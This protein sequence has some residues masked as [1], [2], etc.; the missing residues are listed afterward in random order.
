MVDLTDQEQAA[1]RANV[2]LSV[3]DAYLER[4]L[5]PGIGTI[6]QRFG[7]RPDFYRAKFGLPGHPGLDYSAPAGT[8]VLAC[9]AGHVQVRNNAAGY[10]IYIIIIDPYRKT[11]Y[12]H[13]RAVTRKTG[14]QVRAGQQIGEVGS[15][16]CSDG[17]HLHLGLAWLLG[18]N[19]EYGKWVDPYPFR[20]IYL[21]VN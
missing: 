1:Y 8:P 3:I 18:D 11:L 4:P 15:T 9:H 7:K 20:Q 12:G 13:M 10:G 14:D 19:G 6:S 2:G 21:S 17:N 5:P 16:G